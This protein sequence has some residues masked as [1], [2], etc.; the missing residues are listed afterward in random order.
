M[1]ADQDTGQRVRDRLG[2]EP[3]QQR[4]LD[5]YAPGVALADDPAVLQYADGKTLPLSRI[6]RDSDSGSVGGDAASGYAFAH[7]ELFDK[8]GME[9]A[10]LEF[11]AAGTPVGASRLWATAR[12]W[13][14]F[15]MLYLHNGVVGGERILPAGWVDYFAILTPSSEYARYGAGFWTEL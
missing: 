11:D 3:A 15:G 2:R 7:R 14:R 5:P 12:D 13:A 10:T 1:L 9:H 6:I 4:R 8:L